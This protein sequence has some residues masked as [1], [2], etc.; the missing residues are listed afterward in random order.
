M[1]A[2]Y[3]L[4]VSFRNLPTTECPPWV[5]D[6]MFRNL[7]A[8][9]TGNSHRA[10]FCVDKLYPPEGLGLRLGLLELRA[11]EMTPHVRMGLVNMLLVRALVSVFWRQPFEGSLIRW[12]TA[13]HDRYMLP[14]F[15]RQDFSAVLD[16]LRRHGYL[17]EEKW[18]AAQM[19]FRFPRIGSIAADGVELELRHALEPWN[20]LAEETASGRTV[21][22]VD[23]SLERIQVR[24]SGVTAESR[25]AVTCNGCRVPL[26]P[27]G[28]PGEFVAGIRYRARQLSAVLHPTIP[29]HAPLVFDIIDRWKD[30]SIGR[31]I[32]HVEPPDEHVYPARPVD[33]A[34]AEDR[35]KERFQTEDPTPAPMAAPDEDIN[36]IF[37]MTLD[38][39]LTASGKKT[40]GE[41]TGL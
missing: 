15:V 17:F 8:D 27:T 38:L 33:A 35:R 23:S 7:L 20:V 4:E 1:D 32:Y 16:H 18:F 2:L 34:E 21:R 30:R 36:P 26:T 39:R 37:P 29:V 11:F 5:I 41:S 12:G 40:Q 24:L 9:I 31:C 3:E 14:H 6:G 28:V 13:L 25:F 19:D 22:T 10:E